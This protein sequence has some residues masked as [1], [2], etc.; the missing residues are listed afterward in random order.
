MSKKSETKS[1]IKKET[2]QY[3]KYS[4]LAF[5]MIAIIMVAVF[6]GIKLDEVIQKI[7]FPLFTFVFSILGVVFAIYYAI[8]D[9]IKK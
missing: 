1:E 7:E 3:L 4:N 5:Q 6:G 2:K 9:F 8:K